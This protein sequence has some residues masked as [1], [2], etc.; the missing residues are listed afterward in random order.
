MSPVYKMILTLQLNLSHCFVL[1]IT[2][3][4]KNFLNGTEGLAP[5][6]TRI[7]WLAQPVKLGDPLHHPVT[8]YIVSH[9]ATN[10]CFNHS[11]CVLQVHC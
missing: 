5:Y 8:Y 7:D 10:P 9:S 3:N 4:A 2:E 6:Y 1:F 11:Q